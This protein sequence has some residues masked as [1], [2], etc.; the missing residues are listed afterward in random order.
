MSPKSDIFRKYSYIVC[1]IY[2]DLYD[3]YKGANIGRIWFTVTY[4]SL[5]VTFCCCLTNFIQIYRFFHPLSV[6]FCYFRQKFGRFQAIFSHF[7]SLSADFGH[8]QSLSVTFCRT[9]ADFSH[10]QSLSAE[11]WQISGNFQPLSVTFC[12]HLADFWHFSVTFGHFLQTFGRFLVTVPYSSFHPLPVA[13]CK[14]PAGIVHLQPFS[15]FRSLSAGI[16]QMYRFL[17]ATFS[18]FML[19]SAEIGLIS[20]NFQSVS[21][22]FCRPVPVSSPNH[23]AVP[24]LTSFC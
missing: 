1:Q 10:F 17:T 21:V 4:Q 7:Q 9:F 16:W 24:S 23:I 5:S 2:Y 6:T 12:R 18:H 20:G 15:H 13:S 14:L 8:F 3:C 19:V 22:N 11:I